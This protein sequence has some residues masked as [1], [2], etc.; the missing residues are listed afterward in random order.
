MDFKDIYYFIIVVGCVVGAVRFKKLSASSKTMLGLLLLTLVSEK[1]ADYFK[2]S[3][4]QNSFVY[5]IFNPIQYLLIVWA[6]YQELRDKRLLWSL[7]PIFIFAVF[8]AIWLQPFLRTHNTYFLT[9]EAVAIISIGL[10]YFRNLLNV[11]PTERFVDY[12]LFWFS[13]AWVAFEVI[14]LFV[15]STTNYAA[16]SDTLWHLYFQIRV[17]ANYLLYGLFTVAFL[18]KQ[19]ALNG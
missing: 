6:F 5:H 19:K 2:E 18:S 10:I 9:M 14:L 13:I 16:Q 17:G 12:S 7:L 4:Q 8:N 1:T 3:A 11:P 15:F